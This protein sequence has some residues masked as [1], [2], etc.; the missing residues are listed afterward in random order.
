MKVQYIDA[1]GTYL[2]REKKLLGIKRLSGENDILANVII[3]R[4][5]TFQ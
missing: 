4:C 3:S 5:R 1:E 2:G